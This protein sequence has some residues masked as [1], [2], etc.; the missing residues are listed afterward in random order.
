MLAKTEEDAVGAKANDDEDEEVVP[1]ASV[2]EIIER[3]AALDFKQKDVGDLSL[4]YPGDCKNRKFVVKRLVRLQ[5][6]RVKV[7]KAWDS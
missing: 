5:E 4:I 6:E 2:D 3:M 7:Q 1:E